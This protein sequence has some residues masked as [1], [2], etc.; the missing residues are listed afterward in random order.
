M[1][2]AGAQ[3]LGAPAAR[4]LKSIT[5]RSNAWLDNLAV[6]ILTVANLED[7]YL[8]QLIIDEVYNSVVAL[9]DSE[10]V[11]VACKLFAAVRS[12]VVC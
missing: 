5:D 9:T 7:R 1:R 11:R 6:D 12:G 2:A 8:A 10:P 4:S 3:S